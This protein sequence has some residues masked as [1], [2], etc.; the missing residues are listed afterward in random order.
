VSWF[1]TAML[2]VSLVALT[3]LTCDGV[4]LAISTANPNGIQQTTGG[5]LL[6]HGGHA[7]AFDMDNL[8]S[9]AFLVETPPN[10]DAFHIRI[11]GNYLIST[12][13]S[14]TFGG[15][16]FGDAQII[17][18]D[19]I[20]EVATLFLDFVPIATATFDLDIDA[21]AELP[22]GRIVFSTINEGTISGLEFTENDLVVYDRVTMVAELFFDG[23]MITGGDQFNN[24]SGVGILDE[25]RIALSVSTGGTSTL[26]LPGTQFSRN[27]V[28]IYDRQLALASVLFEGTDIFSGPSNPKVDAVHIVAV[29]PEPSS[30]ALLALA[31]TLGLILAARETWG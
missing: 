5:P 11:N 12:N 1:R 7:V 6:F 17:E 29:V 8:D 3:S 2:S 25:N 16:S 30:L 18:Y 31:A 4:E 24:V 27:D 23:D 26:S 14:V 19:P 15:L 10:L 20:A 13:R 9:A 21:V 28:V 22:D